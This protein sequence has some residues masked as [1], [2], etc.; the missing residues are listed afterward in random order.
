MSDR[1]P[2]DGTAA[3]G[4]V[5]TPP[6][7]RSVSTEDI[8]DALRRGWRDFEEAPFHGLV[9][10]A[11]YAL[12]GLALAF[13]A[14]ESG[15]S[16]LMYP[17][18]IGFA[19]LGPFAAVGLYEIARLRE[20][21][22]RPTWGAIL[23]TLK[24]QGGAELAWMAF[25]TLFVFMAWMYAAQL[26]VAIFFGLDHF[27]TFGE[28]LSLIAT[29]GEGWLFFVIGNA[30]GAAALFVVFSLTVI[31][32]PLLLDRE[33]DFVTAMLTS[34]RAVA[35]SPKPML[36]WAGIVFAILLVAALPAFLGLPVAIPVLGFATWRL[37]RKIVAQ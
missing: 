34:L 26:L 15:L 6:E 24:A 22:V 10:G 9:F 28:F 30:L 16:Y 3:A 31:S 11:V 37:Y 7:V 36:V 14:F 17:A 18:I 13:W 29:T 32:V 4:A 12:G 8:L 1:L 20:K 21:G 5:A 33:V 25:V 2:T 19:M 23:R 27:S 35:T